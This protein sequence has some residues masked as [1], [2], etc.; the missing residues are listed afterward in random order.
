MRQWNVD[1]KLLCR[2]HLLGEHVESHMLL[3]CLKKGISLKGYVEKGLVE[4]HNIRKR[5]DLLAA[6][7]KARGY[8]HESPLDMVKVCKA[9]AVDS[10]RSLKEL[11]KRCP[12]C[13]KRIKENG[14]LMAKD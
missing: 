14:I 7:M 12:E 9:G 1:P 2:R 6:E 11:C 8:K 4:V 13:R 10:E 3:G 5:H